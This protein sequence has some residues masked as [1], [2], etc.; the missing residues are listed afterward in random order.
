[1]IRQGDQLRLSARDKRRWLRITGFDPTGIRSVQ[2]LQRYVD[3]CKRHFWGDSDDTRFL[4]GLMDL[5]FQR[6]VDGEDA[7]EDH[8]FPVRTIRTGL[9]T[10][11]G[12]LKVIDGNRAELERELVRLIV[13]GGK[14]AEPRIAELAARLQPRGDIQIL[15]PPRSSDS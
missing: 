1:M 15:K 2:D 9:R 10:A 4:H 8:A 7:P 6:C 13:L 12:P 3:A 14:D 5:E 11:A